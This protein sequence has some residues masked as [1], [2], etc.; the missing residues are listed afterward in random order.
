MIEETLTTH[1]LYSIYTCILQPFLLKSGVSSLLPIHDCYYY[2]LII[3]LLSVFLIT[4]TIIMT[5]IVSHTKINSDHTL[6]TGNKEVY[7][8]FI[9]VELHA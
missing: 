7:R 9:R 8:V 1:K 2:W 6:K 4:V 3:I 5:I